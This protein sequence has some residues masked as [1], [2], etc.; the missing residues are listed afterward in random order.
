VLGVFDNDTNWD[1]GS[2]I[3][4]KSKKLDKACEELA[5]NVKPPTRF[6]IALLPSTL[7][8][9]RAEA[10]APPI[11]HDRKAHPDLLDIGKPLK[12]IRTRPEPSFDTY[13]RTRFISKRRRAIVV[14]DT[15]DCEENFQPQLL[16]V[17]ERKRRYEKCLENIHSSGALSICGSSC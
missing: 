10:D 17:E 12:V 14:D 11:V 16:D 4:H 2:T 5:E 6:P 9:A 7:A 3:S 8:R 1:V 15:G 13:P